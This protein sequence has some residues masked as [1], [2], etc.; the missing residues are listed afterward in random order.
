MGYHS[1][2]LYKLT[3]YFPPTRISKKINIS[4]NIINVAMMDNDREDTTFL[5]PI[6]N[7]RPMAIDDRASSNID[8]LPLIYNFIYHRWKIKTL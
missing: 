3:V 8:K 7:E 5:M 6:N 2:E 1:R 4:R